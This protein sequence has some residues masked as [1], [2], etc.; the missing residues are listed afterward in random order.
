LQPVGVAH[1][2]AALAPNGTEAPR[3][4]L[5]FGSADA[6]E[7]PHGGRG[8]DHAPVVSTSFGL[9]EPSGLKCPHCHGKGVAPPA[10]PKTP[11]PHGERLHAPAHAALPSDEASVDAAGEAEPARQNEPDGHA[12]SAAPTA[13]APV[14]MSSLVPTSRGGTPSEAARRRVSELRGSREARRKSFLPPSDAE[15]EAEL[16]K[17]IEAEKAEKREEFGRPELIDLDPQPAQPSDS[18]S[19]E[20]PHSSAAQTAL[21]AKAT[22]DARQI[23]AANEHVEKLDHSVTMQTHAH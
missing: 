18:P 2:N 17:Q 9:V 19:T 12:R 6:A 4:P 7:A 13:D 21:A 11:A 5:A 14:S 8:S 22:H 1:S 16:A 20:R 15:V 10:G 23:H 3:P